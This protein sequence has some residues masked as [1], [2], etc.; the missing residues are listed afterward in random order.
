MI[1]MLLQ[2]HSSCWQTCPIYFC[3]LI[4][5]GYWNLSP[6]GED[7]FVN[8]TDPLT[9]LRVRAS[10]DLRWGPEKMDAVRRSSAARHALRWTSCS[11]RRPPLGQSAWRAQSGI[12]GRLP[13]LPSLGQVF[14]WA[15]SY[16]LE[17]CQLQPFKSLMPISQMSTESLK[18]SWGCGKCDAWHMFL[19]LGC[20]RGNLLVLAR[21]AGLISKLM[22]RYV[23]GEGGAHILFFKVSAWA[24][25]MSLQHGILN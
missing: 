7:I 5:C 24:S 18:S 17:T 22:F 3:C 10:D 1:R 12:H 25:W 8:F 14:I 20:F 23:R 6:K 13:S 9:L 15:G 21:P 19:A 16:N 4:P 11:K 2:I